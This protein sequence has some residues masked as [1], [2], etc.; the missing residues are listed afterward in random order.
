M[1]VVADLKNSQLHGLTAAELLLTHCTN[2][3]I[4][5]L[6]STASDSY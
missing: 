4:N 2:Y 6:F 5:R 3:L 1:K